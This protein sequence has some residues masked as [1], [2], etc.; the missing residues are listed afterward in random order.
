[1]TPTIR[2]T[3]LPPGYPVEYE[4]RLVLRD[5][6]E[7]L[8]R[9]VVP[10]DAPQLAWEIAH[11]DTETLYLRFFTPALRIDDSRLRLLTELDY[12]YRFAVA[13]FAPDGEGL[14]IARYEGDPDSPSAEVAVT[15]KPDWRQKGLA[16]AL[17]AILDEAAAAAGISRLEA[18]HLTENE[19][20][21][22][23]LASCGYGNAVV[24]SGMITVSKDLVPSSPPLH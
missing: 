7:A 20:A 14:G 18:I 23:L 1:M 16:S 8:V 10:A 19:A 2:P 6:S 12:R 3:E 9:P 5:G 13:A 17:F 11:A 24:E 21:A 4:R 15:V 22:A